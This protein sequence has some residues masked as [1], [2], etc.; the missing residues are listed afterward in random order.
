M[1]SAI[2]FIICGILLIGAFILMLLHHRRTKI[3]D[4]RSNPVSENQ[5][6]KKS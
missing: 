6:D 2:F 1:V 5:F 3:E 4:Q